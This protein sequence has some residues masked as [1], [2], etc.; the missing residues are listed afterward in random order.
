VK[1][2]YKINC[3]VELGLVVGALLNITLDF[4]HNGSFSQFLHGLLLPSIVRDYMIDQD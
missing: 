2:S 3:R 4:L 1:L